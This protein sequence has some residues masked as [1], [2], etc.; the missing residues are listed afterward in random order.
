MRTLNS[1]LQARP[2]ALVAKQGELHKTPGNE[3]SYMD[4][5]SNAADVMELRRLV[6]KVAQ[7]LRAFYF[8][9]LRSARASVRKRGAPGKAAALEDCWN[10]A[11]GAGGASA[12]AMRAD[13]E[14]ML[15]GGAS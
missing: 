7:D 13:E 11:S 2:S 5:P 8:H 6:G 4:C 12:H 10:T 9:N 1:K 14:R 15:C 3:R